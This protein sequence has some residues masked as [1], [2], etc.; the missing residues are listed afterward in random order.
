MAWNTMNLN[1]ISQ[2]NEN[3]ESQNQERRILQSIRVLK[4]A[5]SD[6]TLST[7]E[8]HNELLRNG[9]LRWASQYYISD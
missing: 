1:P 4:L 5:H 3:L 6:C 8:Y 2:E 7:A 9:I